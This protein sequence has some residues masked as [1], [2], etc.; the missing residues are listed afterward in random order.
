MVAKIIV[1]EGPDATGKSYQ[2][3]LLRDELE[4]SIYVSSPFYT[5][6][7]NGY[8]CKLI[9]ELLQTRLSLEEPK[10]FQKLFAD[11]RKN[12]IKEKFSQ[13]QKQYDY[14]IIDRWNLSTYIYSKVFCVNDRKFLK[15]L[16]NDGLHIDLQFIFENPLGKSFKK[17]P[18]DLFEKERYDDICGQYSRY[19]KDWQTKLETDDIELITLLPQNNIIINSINQTPL[20]THKQIVKYIHEH[21][22]PNRQSK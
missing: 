12:W 18:D 20:E 17:I 22:I 15:E 19:I 14:I 11:N 16:L 13:L 21:F 5:E 3:K 10:I 4:N 2:A 9:R 6:I 7:D 1:F 8:L